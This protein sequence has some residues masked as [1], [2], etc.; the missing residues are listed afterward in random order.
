M[1]TF[2]YGTCSAYKEW[3]L[4]I[5]IGISCNMKCTYILLFLLCYEIH[6]IMLEIVKAALRA[7]PLHSAQPCI[8]KVILSFSFLERGKGREKER[9]RNIDV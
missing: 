8:C 3:D 6:Y 4:S 7:R 1:S 2:F 5:L 9:E